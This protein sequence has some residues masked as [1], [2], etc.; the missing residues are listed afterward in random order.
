M[1]KSLM[2][3][4]GLTFCGMLIGAYSLRI[5]VIDTKEYEQGKLSCSESGGVESFYEQEG[6]IVF[7]CYDGS[8]TWVDREGQ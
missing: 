5:D 4:L 7:Y 3:V 2:Y 6:K 1:N 8:I